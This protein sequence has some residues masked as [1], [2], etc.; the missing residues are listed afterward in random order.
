MWNVSSRTLAYKKKLYKYA[1]RPTESGPESLKTTQVHQSKSKLRLQKADA[2]TIE[3]QVRQILANKVSGNLLG[4]WLLVPEHLRIGSWDL[5]VGWSSQ[6]ASCVEP[7]LC[8]QMVHE[9]ALCVT[10]IR[11]QRCLTHRG[12]ELLNGL[13]FIATDT[14]IHQLLAEHT[15]RQAQNLQIAL[16][17]LR[18]VSHHYQHQ[19]IAL[20]PHRMISYSKRQMPKRCGT[21]QKSPKKNQQL[22]FALDVDTCQPVACTIG[23][24]SVTATQ[25]TQEL[26]RLITAILPQGSL[27]L[28][29]SEHV[30]LTLLNAIG[31]TPGFD[32]LIPAPRQPYRIKQIQNIPE[33]HF[34]RHWAGY[35]TACIPYQ[36]PAAKVPLYL[37]VQRNGEQPHQYFYNCFIA[38]NNTERV[39]QLTAEFPKRWHVEEFFNLEQSMGWRRSG[40]LN[41]NIRYARASFALLAQAALHQL[42]KRLGLP[43]EQYTAQHFA[44]DLFGRLDGDLKVNKDTII[45]TYYNAPNVESLKYHYENLPQKLQNEGVDPR[46]PWLYNFKLDFRFR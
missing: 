13:P 43:Y 28:A 35:A 7:R 14:A 44:Q 22:F 42:R 9:A 19:V 31:Q 27:I 38:T 46:V 1:P 11:Q 29:D 17:K 3:R 41:L 30:G 33:S 26:M 36:P 40:T 12:F 15:V 21:P 18:Y 45:V 23:S 16:G 32:L 20:D 8:L 5:L 39:R 4:L 24:S 37:F 6:P 34:Q 2:A 10:G 25:G